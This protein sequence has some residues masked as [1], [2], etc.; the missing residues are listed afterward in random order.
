M[1][2]TTKELAKL[3]KEYS[4]H[5]Q[6]LNELLFAPMIA[7]YD[8]EIA[9]AISERKRLD[10]EYDEINNKIDL[11]YKKDCAA[12]D[13]LPFWKKWLNNNPR[14]DFYNYRHHEPPF[15]PLPQFP[16]SIELVPTVTTEGFLSWLAEQKDT[17]T[18]KVKQ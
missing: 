11:R 4:D 12:Y 8:K 14:V 7:K 6:I 9:E 18:G 1:K 17:E 3:W 2:Q 15:I 16:R 10:K 13:K 5:A